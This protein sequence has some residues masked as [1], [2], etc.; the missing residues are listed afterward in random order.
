MQQVRRIDRTGDTA[1]EFAPGETQ[2]AEELFNESRAQGYAAVGYKDGSGE[3]VH[4]FDPSCDE[5]ILRPPMV[6]G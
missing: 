6:G 5:I 2:E 3:V 4:S 1:V